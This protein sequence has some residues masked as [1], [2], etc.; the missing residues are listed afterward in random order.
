M[1]NIINYKKKSKKFNTQTDCENANNK[2]KIKNIKNSKNENSP[3][4]ILGYMKKKKYK[5]KNNK[6]VKNINK[7]ITKN[8]KTN[9]EFEGKKTK[10]FKKI[11]I[12]SPSSP[13]KKILSIKTDKNNTFN[14]SEKTVNQV[15][16]FFQKMY[17]LI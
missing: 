12:S 3:T 5:N 14:Y 15:I 16:Y 6:I 13:P 9:V 1:K 10:N 11:N 7:K 8:L 17:I 4:I 2:N